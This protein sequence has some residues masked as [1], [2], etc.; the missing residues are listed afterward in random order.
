[1]KIC[2]VC[3]KERPWFA[4]KDSD[5]CIYCAKMG[6]GKRRGGNPASAHG[7][8]VGMGTTA[9]AL[10]PIKLNTLKQCE[11]CGD[12]VLIGEM[13]AHLKTHGGQKDREWR[14]VFSKR[15]AE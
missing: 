1:M 5:E 13:E 11:A 4:Y 12:V 2:G 15:E 3:H 10:D 14:K 9:T 6:R 7:I 8:V